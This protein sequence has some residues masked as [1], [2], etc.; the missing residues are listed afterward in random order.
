M[1]KCWTEQGWGKH[2]TAGGNIGS[3][4]TEAAVEVAL[5]DSQDGGATQTSINRWVH[6]ENVV[7]AYSGILLSHKRTWVSGREAD[8]PR[9]CYIKWSNSEREKKY[10]ILTRIYE[11]RKMVP[12]TYFQ[13]KNR[14]TDVGNGPVDTDGK[15]GGWDRWRKE[16]WH[17]YRTL[18]EVDSRWEAAFIHKAG[19]PASHSVMTW[20][21][22][23][24]VGR[25]A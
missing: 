23:M 11:P 25:E 21:S 17:I 1:K 12:W 10:C 9:A 4:G 5:R 14:D 15:R 24:G 2:V 8:G 20:R 13:G 6:K 18:C 19:S 7:H 3:R 16:R 22:G